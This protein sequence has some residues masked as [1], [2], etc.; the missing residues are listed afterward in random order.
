MDWS[1][2]RRRC[3]P[4]RTGQEQSRS[5]SG[6]SYPHSF[7]ADISSEELP[8]QVEPEIQGFRS[9]ASRR[10]PEGR[11]GGVRDVHLEDVPAEALLER[12]AELGL[13]RRVTAQAW[14]D[15]AD[16]VDRGA[17]TDPR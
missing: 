5:G 7:S 14:G 8:R 1:G 13:A 16:Q 15:F 11:A 3:K 9:A 6:V 12:E 10:L 2:C 4:R 17:Y